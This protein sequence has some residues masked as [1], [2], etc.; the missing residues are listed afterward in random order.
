[1]KPLIMYY[2][3]LFFFSPWIYGLGALRLGHKSMWEKLG[4]QLT[5][6]PYNSVS[7]RNTLLIIYN[8][9]RTE[10]SPIQSVSIQVIIKIRRLWKVQFINHEYNYRM[11]LTTRCPVT[12]L[13]WPLQFLIKVNSLKMA[14]KSLSKQSPETNKTS[15]ISKSLELVTI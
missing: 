7:K 12:T 14:V 5:E 2:G 15:S 10:W 13:S 11:N 8:G 4:S 9:N 6:W 3:S 1:M